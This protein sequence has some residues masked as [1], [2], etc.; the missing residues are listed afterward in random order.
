MSNHTRFYYAPIRVAESVGVMGFV[1]FP[2]EP[3]RLGFDHKLDDAEL[4]LLEAKYGFVF[5]LI[6]EE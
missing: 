3:Y 4:A 2:Q 6:H 1:A 5:A